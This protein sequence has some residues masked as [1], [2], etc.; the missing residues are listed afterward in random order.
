MRPRAAGGRRGLLAGRCAPRTPRSTH[1]PPRRGA[2]F[3]GRRIGGRQRSRRTVQPRW[4]AGSATLMQKEEASS[5]YFPQGALETSVNTVLEYVTG[6][7]RY[8]G[9]RPGTRVDS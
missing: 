1:A 3:A 6:N 4:P 9:Q 7:G 8:A 2:T 5:F